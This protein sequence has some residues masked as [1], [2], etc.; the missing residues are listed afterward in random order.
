MA[1]MKANGLQTWGEIK[2]QSWSYAKQ[3]AWDNVHI[4]HIYLVT[5]ENNYKTTLHFIVK[6]KSIKQIPNKF[7]LIYLKH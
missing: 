3:I 6:P 4:L 5:R 2:M 1:N 7:L